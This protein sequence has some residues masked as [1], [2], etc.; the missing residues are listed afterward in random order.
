MPLESIVMVWGLVPVVPRMVDLPDG[1]VAVTVVSL[2]TDTLVAAVPPIFTPVAPVRFVPV[3]VTLVPPAIG[4]PL[5]LILVTV[6][7]A[8]KVYDVVAVPDGVVTSTVAVPADPA[9]IWKVR[10]VVVGVA[11][12]GVSAV[13]PIVTT[14][15]PKVKFVPL[16]VTSRLLSPDTG[17]LVGL[18]LVTVGAAAYVYS[19]FA[20]FVPPGVV[21][22]TL[23]VPA[24]FAGVVAVIVVP[25]VTVTLV[26]AS[27]PIVT[28]VA[29]VNPVPVIVTAWLP[30]T[31]PLVGLILVTVGTA[32]YVYSVSPGLV[33]PTSVVTTTNTVPTLR[34]GVVAVI[35]VSLTTVKLVAA[36]ALNVTAVAPVNPVP[37]MVTVWLPATGPVAGLIAVT[38]RGAK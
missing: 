1:V 17:P 3:M 20:E 26:A 27:A 37:V 2:P 7:A 34:A 32:A 33:P 23:A 8:T 14:V 21:T 10:V 9:G 19:V 4:P 30:A 31:G 36:V 25:L 16:I 22:S 15:V 6:G 5:G 11:A 38:V 28:A 13:P 35:V 18:I 29:P 24:A 12:P